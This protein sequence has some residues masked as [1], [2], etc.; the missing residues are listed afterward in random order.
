MITLLLLAGG[1]GGLLLS[2]LFSGFETAAYTLNRVRLRLYDE[3]GRPAAR[4]LARLMER[5]DDVVLMA[6]LGTVVADYLISICVAA[7]LVQGAVQN[8]AAIE[9]YTTLIVTPAVLVLGAMIPKEWFRREVDRLMYP[10]APVLLVCVRLA[11]ATGVVW[12]FRALMRGLFRWVDPAR[13]AR[14]E[15]VY[16]RAG[17]LRMLREGAVGGK[18]T[19]FQLDLFERVMNL[20]NVRVGNVMI[21]RQRAAMLPEDVSRDDF[22]RIAKLA[23]LSRY[24]LFRGDPRHI[25]GIVSVFDLLASED[26]RLVKDHAHPPFFLRANEPVPAALLKLQQARQAMAVVQDAAGH[27][28]GILTIKDLV[29]EVVGELEVW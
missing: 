26:Q 17:T 23:H 18:L 3:T 10:L 13:A 20:S 6:M 1:I 27:C 19:R 22:M 24:P 7:V 28:V 25:V 2:A 11:Q 15:P 14:E 5:S 9:L 16:S 8:V 21:P 4:T 12:L 29:E